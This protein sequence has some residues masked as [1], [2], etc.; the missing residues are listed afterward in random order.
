LIE[1]R[2]AAAQRNDPGN[3]T[4]MDVPCFGIAN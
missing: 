2:L 4:V 3:L 1:L